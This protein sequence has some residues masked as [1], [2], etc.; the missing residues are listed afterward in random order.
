[1]STVTMAVSM[2]EKACNEAILDIHKR[3][4][5][6]GAENAAKRWW[7][8]PA[9]SQWAPFFAFGRDEECCKRLLSLCKA[10]RAAGKDEIQVSAEDIEAFVDLL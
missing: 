7:Q 2:V 10:A 5:T 6:M 1:M 8:R 9:H 4:K 3:R